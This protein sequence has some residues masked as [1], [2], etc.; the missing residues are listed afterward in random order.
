MIDNGET[1][2][3]RRDDLRYLRDP[4]AIVI[5]FD[6]D[7]TL[8]RTVLPYAGFESMQYATKRFLT[9]GVSDVQFYTGRII[10]QHE[11]DYG[12]S[13]EVTE[14]IE[15]ALQESTGQTDFLYLLTLF[16]EL[17][18]QIEH[19]ELHWP[20]LLRLFAIYRSLYKYTSE[21]GRSSS[22]NSE[23]YADAIELLNW[24]KQER[25]KSANLSAGVCTGNPTSNTLWKTFADQKLPKGVFSLLREL[26][27]LP[28]W[29][30]T[31]N[32]HRL[33]LGGDSHYFYREDIYRGLRRPTK[34]FLLHTWRE[35]LNWYYRLGLNQED[36]RPFIVHID[37]K[38]EAL[39]EFDDFP[40]SAGI[41]VNRKGI[42]RP[43]YLPSNV[44]EVPDLYPE[45]IF[46][47]LGLAQAEP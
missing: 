24:I 43:E 22:L 44:F 30:N 14:A 41:W 9:E 21:S 19:P 45:T 46:P 2:A 27:P 31:L 36:C 25:G 8:G 47:I 17:N 35:E 32:G 20:Q 38:P 33:I 34:Q 37:D 16:R 39:I 40:N 42:Q 28:L 4:H 26:N 7:E 18:I 10:P 29:H 13:E 5:F 1:P 12:D 11:S 15:T 6:L 23:P 3:E